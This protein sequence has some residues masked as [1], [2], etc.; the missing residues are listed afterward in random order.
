MLFTSV[1]GSLKV[2]GILSSPVM[3]TFVQQMLCKF[4]SVFTS[5]LA[6]GG[7]SGNLTPHSCNEI[8]FPIK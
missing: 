3:T 5:G 1:E 7:G 8:E 6:K 4:Y 2:L